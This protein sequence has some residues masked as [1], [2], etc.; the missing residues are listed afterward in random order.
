M[1]EFGKRLQQECEQ[2]GPDW[3]NH[4]IDYAALK[5]LIEKEKEATSLSAEAIL[6]ILDGDSAALVA[7]PSPGPQYYHQLDG[8]E[9]ASPTLLFRYALDREIEKAVLYV[10][11]DQGS[12]AA[13]LDRLAVRRAALVDDASALLRATSASDGSRNEHA[14]IRATTEE[15]G[16]IHGGYAQAARRVLR[17]V[18]FVDL[19][20]TAVR[21][22]LKKHDKITRGKL[23][24]SYLSDYTD[25]YVDSHL[26]QLY[27]D[28][29]LSSL[30]VTLRRAFDELRH[31]ELR[32]ADA[33][34]REG[35]ERGNS[36]KGGGHR[37]IRSMPANRIADS[38]VGSTEGQR[39][40]EARPSAGSEGGGALVTTEKE[41]L[42]Q[43]I[44][45]SRDRLRRNTEYVDVVAAQALMFAE[46]D[47]EE[48]TSTA[49]KEMTPSQRLSSF[50]NLLS[51][52][53]YMTNYY[54]V[55]PTC[56]R[57]AER[58]G[59]SESMAGIVIGMTP[60]A[61]LVAT[62]LYGW[63]SNHSYKSALVFAAACSFT[64]N[65]AYALAL[66]YDS[67]N[68]I[69][70]GRALNGFGSAR[71]INRESSGWSL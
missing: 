71:S 42:L 47:D 11:K 16:R 15:L 9:E 8:L 31:V 57:Y 20:V 64:G 69:L 49:E 36:N 21:K 66:K 56:G 46:P 62:V 3:Q 33:T 22:I 2:H 55:A 25:E 65:V 68:L 45:L 51:T 61:A 54:I 29:G 43:M 38:N 24:F 53:L 63:W 1:V 59:S 23:S 32:L 14:R 5:H 70:L 52:F 60:N 39:T 34:A 50:L 4:C 26:D 27:N 58:V 19:N 67:I 37:R 28:G 44:Q 7:P 41:P 35:E 6:D 18:A 13:E 40:M 12:I 17:F 30:A 10:L 48:D